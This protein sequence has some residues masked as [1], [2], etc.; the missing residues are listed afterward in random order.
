MHDNKQLQQLQEKVS[1]K[2]RL[3]AKERT[4]VSTGRPEQAR[5]RIENS[6]GERA[7][8]CGPFGTYQSDSCVL[9]CHWQKRRYA[10]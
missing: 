2:K 4:T 10:G 8:R 9:C 1:Q 7:G 6:D 3:E 5:S